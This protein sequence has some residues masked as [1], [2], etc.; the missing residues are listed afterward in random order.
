[1]RMPI[2]TNNL[3]FCNRS[4]ATGDPTPQE[5][6]HCVVH[7][8]AAFSV[9]SA[10]QEV[11]ALITLIPLEGKIELEAEVSP[12]DIAKVRVGSA[13]RVK[14]NAWPF[15]QYGTLDGTIRNVSENTIEKPGVPQS[16]YYRV[17]AVVSGQLKN[18]G[19]DFRLIPGMEAVTEIKCGRR[20]IIEFVL[21]PLLKALD[22]TA[23][24]P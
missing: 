3:F 12:Q 22:E 14:L 19:A 11:E 5:D 21:Y 13:A 9:G 17:R 23:R 18:P 10:V 4:P 24:E 2:Q 16:A 20:R 7:E 8:I 1:M 6:K 15:Q